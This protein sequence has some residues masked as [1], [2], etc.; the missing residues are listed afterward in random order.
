MEQEDYSEARTALTKTSNDD[1][2][3]DAFGNGFTVGMTTFS[4]GLLLHD[5]F[6]QGYSVWWL[7]MLPLFVYLVVNALRRQNNMY[8]S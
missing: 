6:F 1:K 7:L 8:K 3:N 2:V 4:I 5:V